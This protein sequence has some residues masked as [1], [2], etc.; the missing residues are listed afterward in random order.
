MQHSTLCICI[1]LYHPAMSLFPFT[2]HNILNI[3]FPCH[4]ASRHVSSGIGTALAGPAKSSAAHRCSLQC[5]G[6]LI[7]TGWWF[8]LISKIL[9]NWDDYFQYMEK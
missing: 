8:Q 3:E 7:I 4:T 9:V 1:Y 6:R 2:Q 5:A